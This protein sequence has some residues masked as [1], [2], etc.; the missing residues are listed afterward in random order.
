MIITFCG[1]SKLYNTDIIKDRLTR[2]LRSLSAQGTHTFYLGGYGDFDLLAANVL[3]ELKPE[4]PELESI[5]ILPYPDRQ[6]DVS[7]YDGTIYPPLENVPKRFAISHRNRWM[8]DQA[9]MVIAYVDHDW[10]GAEKTLAMAQK[11][12]LPIINLA[13]PETCESINNTSPR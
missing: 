13:E 5:L 1:H 3:H 10:G 12:K 8:V 11:K 7:L 2:E 4:Y 9:D 6:V